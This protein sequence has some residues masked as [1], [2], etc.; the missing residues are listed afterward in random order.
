MK[1]ATRILFALFALF[2]TSFGVKAS[3]YYW[4]GGTGVW[5][6]FANHWATTSGGTTFQA[7]IP[8]VNDDI[9]FDSNSFTSA[10]QSVSFDNTF[11]Y[12]KNM[13][14]TG[15]Q[16][17]PSFQGAGGTLNVSGS[18]VLD[19][20]VTVQQMGLTLMSNTPGNTLSTFGQTFGYV[21]FTGTGAYTMQS[22]FI[23]EGS[24]MINSGS[25]DAN[26]YNITCNNLELAPLSTL[27]TGDILIKIYGTNFSV[28][29]RA[30][31]AFGT[32]PTASLTNVL[33]DCV[34]GEISGTNTT[35]V[36]DSVIFN[37]AG[38]IRNIS[39][40][41]CSVVEDGFVEQSTIQ[42]AIFEKNVLLFTTTFDTLISND[43]R[44]FDSETVTINNL[45]T[46]TADCNHFGNL[47]S[48]SAALGGTST[49]V[50]PSGAIAI[51]YTNV[52]GI[53]A[54]G[55]AS[56]TANNSIDLGNNT[57]WTINT[58]AS[59][60]LYWIGGTG[61]WN[62]PAHWSLTS[63]GASVACVPSPTDNVFFDSNSFSANDSIYLI[64]QNVFL[65]NF[66]ANNLQSNVTFFGT[67]MTVNGDFNLLSTANWRVSTLY[68]AGT[69]N[70]TLETVSPLNF[71]EIFSTAN[72][73]V[74]SDLHVSQFFLESGSMDIS[75]R[76]IYCTS[77]SAYPLTT[78]TMNNAHLF[79]QS[80]FIDATTPG[81]LT[82]KLTMDAPNSR[83]YRAANI[84]EVEFLYTGTVDSNLTA[85]LFTNYGTVNLGHHNNIRK[86]IAHGNLLVHGDNTIDTLDLGTNC[87][88]LIQDAGMT[89]T[90]NE[91]FTADGGSC[92]NYIEIKSSNATQQTNF[93][94]ASG[95]PVSIFNV[96]LEATNV[97]G[98]SFTASQSINSGN[99]TGWAINPPAANVMYWVG[100]PGLWEDTLH[101]SYSSGGPSISC[102][103]SSVDDVIFDSNS[104]VSGGT[105]GTTLEKVS[106]NSLTMT[107]AGSGITFNLPTM[108]VDNNVILEAGM[109]F[110]VNEM[111][112]RAETNSILRSA[113]NVLGEITINGSGL[114][115]LDDAL[116]ATA[117]ALVSGSFDLNG[118]DLKAS[119]ISS[120]LGTTFT[121]GPV[122]IIATN[123]ELEGTVI[124]TANTDID[125][126]FFPPGNFDYGT[127][128]RT[129]GEFRHINVFSNTTFSAR[130]FKCQTL[131][132][133]SYIGINANVSQDS[134]GRFTLYN[135]A[136]IFG[137]W[138]F[139]TLFANNPGHT[140]TMSGQIEIGSQFN[141][142]GT[143]GF[144]VYMRGQASVTINKTGDDVCLHNTFLEDVIAGGPANFYAGQGCSDLTGN[145]NW[146]FTACSTTSDVWPGDANYDLVCNNSDILNIGVA[147]N[148]SGPVRVGG[149][150]SWTAQPAS[151]YT[152]FFANAVNM[153]HADCDGNGVVD[154][155]DTTVVG[156]NYSLTHPAR[157]AAP[158]V[159]TNAVLPLLELIA[160]PDTVGP[161]SPVS[162]EALLGSTALPVDSMYGI[163][164][165]INYD[166]T[167][168]DTNSVSANFAGSW[169]GTDGVDMITFVRHFPTI[170]KIDIAMVRNDHVNILNGSGHLA[171][172]D[173]VIVDNI[174]TVTSSLF[175]LTDVTAITYTQF[176]QSLARMNDSVVV[177]PLFDGVQ[178]VDLSSH[179]MIYPNPA[180]SELYVHANDVKVDKAEIYDM[181]GRLLI[182]KKI[183][184][185]QIQMNVDGLS[186][187]MYH[188]RCYSDKG[189]YNSRIQII[190]R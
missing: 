4:V 84:N 131:N 48:Y 132:A 136:S 127:G 21:Q 49:I 113:G 161:L 183:V 140:M 32:M 53:I 152:N 129:P 72:Y 55:G 165:T 2:L 170:G 25:L 12:C 30:F 62:D 90:I 86:L 9:V 7:S 148:E 189:I 52:H 15:V 42:K 107:G 174:S 154:I 65:K 91:Q 123:F 144:P 41:Y 78:V 46:V 184:N 96:D 167:V 17:S 177:D 27:T 60:D 134:I 81:S 120:A 101:W 40:N 11:Y 171:V 160:T 37:G 36:F 16:F 187:G 137:N 8:T 100:G 156:Q 28:N 80:Y 169:L 151:D 97:S 5:S 164:F 163:S 92:S 122:K 68:L 172:F 157:L 34:S 22:E 119:G 146:Q 133:Y 82:A 147:F 117:V 10:G 23:S 98:G 158:N 35:T 182:T 19:P 58:V 67:R 153:K 20:T 125:M 51:D 186:T 142:N 33:F 3:T 111:I 69:T 38:T 63:G 43:T 110:N 26:G 179:F 114:I 181:E 57:G 166:P 150:T 102:V 93:V 135:D 39:M 168:I 13:T 44:I 159:S 6:D 112:L 105:I 116:T 83:I 29:A 138:Y 87:H 143:A 1:T 66:N 14:W 47:Y 75:N 180:T 31:N 54:S 103:P 104:G 121:V 61:N 24:L 77:F 124:N 173:V 73:T 176:V 85:N 178:H 70:S 185:N 18:L 126:M 190:N 175:H 128:F 79:M 94:M 118:F 109:T 149:N 64:D 115:T 74:N 95:N 56:F 59:R 155:N 162:I 71:L 76:N 145:T 139:D 106:M 141:S 88:A 99:N 89:M 188:L 45:L 50:C 130:P 108:S